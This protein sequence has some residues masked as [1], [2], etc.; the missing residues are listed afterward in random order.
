MI[1]EKLFEVLSRTMELLKRYSPYP[2][3]N[4]RQTLKMEFMN[5]TDEE[6]NI[7]MREIAQKDNVEFKGG[8]FTYTGSQG[9]DK[10]TRGSKFSKKKS[11][12]GYPHG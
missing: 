5:I 7:I 1:D 12:G 6:I 2:M 3:G 4:L 11:I 8:Y 9:Y 10:K